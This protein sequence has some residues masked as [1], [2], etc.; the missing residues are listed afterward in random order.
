M[1]ITAFD[2][3]HDIAQPAKV[4]ES[5]FNSLKSDGTFLMVDLAASSNLHENL[6][7]P[8]GP[9]LYTTSCL[10]CMTVS[11]AQNGAGLGTMWGEQ[12]A[13]QML[14]GAGF[15]NVKVQQIPGDIFNNYYIAKKNSAT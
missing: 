15:K 10:H 9:W 13:L 1:L 8:L 11:L 14:D 12:K 7:H 2:V 3:I 4:L 5:I 6:N